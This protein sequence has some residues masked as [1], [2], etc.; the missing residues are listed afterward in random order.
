MKILEMGSFQEEFYNL[1]LVFLKNYCSSSFIIQHSNLI[2]KFLKYPLMN[3]KEFDGFFGYLK[4][5]Q[6]Q[7]KDWIFNHQLFSDQS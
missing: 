3:A 1:C 7:S 2:I 4:N 5:R 6:C